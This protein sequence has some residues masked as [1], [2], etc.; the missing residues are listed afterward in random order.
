[1]I[2]TQRSEGMVRMCQWSPGC[3]NCKYPVKA[4]FTGSPSASW[5]FQHQASAVQGKGQDSFTPADTSFEWNILQGSLVVASLLGVRHRI[6]PLFVLF[7]ACYKTE[8]VQDGDMAEWGRLPVFSQ[9][10]F[11]CRWQ[12][13][14]SK[15]E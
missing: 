15:H 10:P 2:V 12:H 11:M 13:N 4:Q 7:S 14:P 8:V 3:R 5:V 9:C 1:M 6:P